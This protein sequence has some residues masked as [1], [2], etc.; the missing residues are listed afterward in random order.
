MRRA[1]LA[2]ILA[3]ATTSVAAAQEA[4]TEL[5][6]DFRYSYNHADP[7]D[8]THWASAN[9]ASRLGVRGEL[10]DGGLT[11]FYDLQTGVN[12]DAET[13]GGAFTQRYYFAGVRGGFGAITI[14]RQS[15]AYKMAG[16][17]KDPFYDSS[18]LSAG[19]GVPTTGLFAG[20]SFGLSNLTNGF[21]D[22]TLSYTSPSLGGITAN[23]AAYIDTDSDHDYGLGIGYRAHG[24][25]AGVQYHEVDAGRTWAST[26]G[27]DHAVRGHAGY[28]RPGVW[29]VGTSFERVEAV[30]G[31][32]QDFLFAAGTVNVT[33]RVAMAAGVGHV[34]DSGGVQPVAGTA[35]HTGVFFSLFQQVRL[36]ALFSRLDA[37]T[38]PDRANLGVG[39]SYQFVLGR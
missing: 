12:I 15:T 25:D 28:A 6:G 38:G 13:I 9:N 14:G 4:S 18:T 29:S 19:G 16:L 37:A 32:T 8:S 20:A 30:T 31:E 23:A 17:R 35:L 22:R 10:S 24:F 2:L 33:P 1:A 3:A 26:L 5:Y 11:A 21:A 27:V 7:G 34:E 36:H 39:L